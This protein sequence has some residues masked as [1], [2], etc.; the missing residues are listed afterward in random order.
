MYSGYVEVNQTNGRALFYWLVE[1]TDVDPLVKS[2]SIGPQRC[3]KTCVW[4]ATLRS[5]L[6]AYFF[7]MLMFVL[8][9]KTAP[10]IFW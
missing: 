1:A 9:L 3:L 4:R 6:Q 7:G 8:S 5:L 2:P 10:L